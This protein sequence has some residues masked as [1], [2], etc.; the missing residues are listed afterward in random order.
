MGGICN[1]SS[2][3][4]EAVLARRLGVEMS[5]TDRHS[6]HF[7]KTYLCFLMM[8]ECTANMNRGGT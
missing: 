5:P 6:L 8:L 7:L 1:V 3:L 2:P 4:F